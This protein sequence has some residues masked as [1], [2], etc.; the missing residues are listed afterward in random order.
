M[1]INRRVAPNEKLWL[2]TV[3]LLKKRRFIFTK[4][5]SLYSEFAGQ[6][7]GETGAGRVHFPLPSM[8]ALDTMPTTMTGMHTQPYCMCI[9]VCVWKEGKKE[10][11]TRLCVVYTQLSPP[12]ILSVCQQHPRDLSPHNIHHTVHNTQ[13]THLS[14][15]LCLSLSPHILHLILLPLPLPSFSSYHTC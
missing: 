15:S 14:L 2:F 5:T 12:Y 3:T 6:M 4:A 1:I 7:E 11:R 10:E 8:L 13:H 9:C